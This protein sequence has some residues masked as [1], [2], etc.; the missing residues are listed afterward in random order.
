MTNPPAEILPWDSEFFGVR[1]ARAHER[2]PFDLEGARVLVEWCEAHG[3][4]WLY[5]LVPPAPEAIRAA[6]AHSF[7]LT[8]IRVEFAGPPPGG[9]GPGGATVRRFRDEDLPA[10][11]RLAAISHTDSRFFADPR[12]PEGRAALLFQRWIERDCAPHPDAWA[13]V[14]ESD[15]RP[16]GYVTASLDGSRRGWIRLIAVAEQARGRG[17]GA[18]LVGAAGAWMRERGAVEA[19]VVSQGRNRAARRL[20]Q[21]GGLQLDSLHLW[22][23]RWFGP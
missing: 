7:A 3:V 4:R 22:Y 10:L 1:V 5:A 8:D 15:G 9:R 18:A 13:G 12:V 19:R 2:A 14:A 23:H 16:V 11:L 21:Q 17:V 6:E 20:Y